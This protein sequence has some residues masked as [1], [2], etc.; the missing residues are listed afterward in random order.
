MNYPGENKKFRVTTS[1]P[2]FQLSEDD[3]VIVILDQYGRQRQTITKNDCFW[4]DQGQWYF[5]IDPIHKGVFYA[6]FTGAY[7]DDDFDGQKRIFRDFQELFRVAYRGCPC[8]VRE[9]DVSSQCKCKHVVHYEEVW[10]VS[11]DGDD[12]LCGSDGKYIL[13]SDGKRICFKNPKRKIIEDMGK[14]ILETMT[15]DEFKRFIEGDNPDGV[16]DTVPEMM[17]AAQ[18]IADTETIREDVQEQI[19]ED[20]QQNMGTREDIDEIFNQ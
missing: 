10:S 8:K 17:R 11:I 9:S 7:E 12:Y 4:D 18:G 1:Q 6:Y 14:V 2:D 13:T 15:G 3:F 16:I 19:E 20:R 5:T